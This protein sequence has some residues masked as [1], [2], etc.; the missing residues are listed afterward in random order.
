MFQRIFRP[1]LVLL[2]SDYWRYGNASS[3]M[4]AN[5]CEELLYRLKH[6]QRLF[7]VWPM[8]RISINFIGLPCSHMRGAYAYLLQFLKILS[9][10]NGKLRYLFAAIL[11]AGIWRTNFYSIIVHNW[12]IL[13]S[14]QILDGRT[15]DRPAHRAKLYSVRD[16]IF[17]G[18][19]DRGP[20]DRGPGTRDL[21]PG[22]PIWR[23]VPLAPRSIGAT[24]CLG[25]NY[26][27]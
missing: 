6:T 26:M 16:A 24:F 18:P 20:G 22:D 21:G 1:T 17:S 4:E 23:H 27:R 2:G 15:L 7:T 9:V 5:N 8:L 10:A 25:Y 14:K 19:G 13:S 11:K 12:V 3:M